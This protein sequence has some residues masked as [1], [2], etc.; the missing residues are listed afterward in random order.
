MTD[1]AMC[2]GVG[3]HKCG[4]CYRRTARPDPLVQAY[5][6]RPPLDDYG[7]CSHFID[8]NDWSKYDPEDTE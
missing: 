4:F 8:E 3:L 1:I 6:S 2:K 7:Q 5:L